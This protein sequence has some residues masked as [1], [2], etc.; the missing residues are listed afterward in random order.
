M[1]AYPERF[2]FLADTT[3]RPRRDTEQTATDKRFVS[4]A[5]FTTM[6]Y[7]HRFVNW[8]RNEINGEYYGTEWSALLDPI[9]AGRVLI[10]TLDCTNVKHALKS[11]KPLA[12]ITV[13]ARAH[14]VQVEHARACVRR[15][16]IAVR[17]AHAAA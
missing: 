5:E 14:Y 6:V 11:L 4:R 12:P 9:T 10:T 17:P 3:T 16:C 8:F 7:R 2:A 1:S 15:F 13:R